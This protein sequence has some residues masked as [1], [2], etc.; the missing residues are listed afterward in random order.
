MTVLAAAVLSPAE[1]FTRLHGRFYA[2]AL[3]FVL[4]VFA[5]FGGEIAWTGG[6][7]IALGISAAAAL[8]LAAW[9]LPEYLASP[10]RSALIVDFPELGWAAFAGPVVPAAAGALLIL[11]AAAVLIT[12]KPKAYPAVLLAVLALANIG[13]YRTLVRSFQPDRSALR[14]ARAF[15]AGQISDPEAGV[16]VFSRGGLPRW[17]LAFWHPYRYTR[18]AE[19][20]ADGLLRREMIPAGTEFVVVFGE[21]RL[22]FRPFRASH[23]AGCSV[24]EMFEKAD[25]LGDFV[26]VYHDAPG[27]TWTGRT[28][29]YYPDRTFRSLVL[30]LNERRPYFPKILDIESD[31][32]PRRIRLDV[33]VERIELP[34]SNYYR[35]RLEKAFS[36][37]WLGLNKDDTRALGISL[38]KAF[39]L[40]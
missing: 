32:G 6:R 28:F 21:W 5:A 36:P 24:L 8:G 2:A 15:V 34:F 23:R 3:P 33:G 30:V 19:I 11:L 35:F 27:W 16:A 7:K 4:V 39:I 12:G 18:S 10:V 25:V 14:T 40:D 17:L 38:R 9:S 31:Q 22:D 20:P 1:A 37:R 26:G 13:H 29:A